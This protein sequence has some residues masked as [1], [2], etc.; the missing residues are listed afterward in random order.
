MLPFLTDQLIGATADELRTVVYWYL[1]AN[2]LGKGLSCLFL[3]SKQTILVVSGA[4]IVAIPPAVIII[5][6]CLCQQWL[7]QTHHKVII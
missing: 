1:W 6:D 2:S 4:A 3:D 5:S 7:D